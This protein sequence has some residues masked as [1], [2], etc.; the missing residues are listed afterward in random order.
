MAYV[1]NA[2]ARETGTANPLLVPHTCGSGATLLVLSLVVVA[3][4][5]RTGVSLAPDV[6]SVA[7]GDEFSVYVDQIGSTIAGSDLTI[8]VIGTQLVVLA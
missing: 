4:V 5:A 7:E 2:K 1:F 6:T 8:E 3:N